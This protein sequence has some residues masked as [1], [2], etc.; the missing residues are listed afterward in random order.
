LEDKIMSDKMSKF[1]EE[2]LIALEELAEKL[3]IS[4]QTLTRKING[5]TDWTYPEIIILTELFHIEDPESFF[6]DRS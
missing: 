1:M 6:F 5:K 3:S 4:K 2:F